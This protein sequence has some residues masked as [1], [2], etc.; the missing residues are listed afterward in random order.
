MS[1]PMAGGRP[2]APPLSAMS[3]CLTVRWPMTCQAR[4][5]DSTIGLSRR[6][7]FMTGKTLAENV[8][9]HAAQGLRPTSVC[10]L[11]CELMDLCAGLAPACAVYGTAASLPMLAEREK[12]L[13]GHESHMHSRFQRPLS[14]W[15]DDP[16]M[17]EG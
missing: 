11:F 16:A 15:L 4:L 2:A 1:M 12:W 9:A 5:S 17:A 3:A 8:R 13:P 10:V 14:Y 7:V 6:L